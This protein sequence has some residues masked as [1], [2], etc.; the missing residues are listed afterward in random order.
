MS[1]NLE[2]QI[3]YPKIVVYN[4]VFEDCDKFLETAKNCEIWQDWYTFGTMMALQE[5][6]FKF[7]KFPTKEEYINAR[8]WE[9]NTDNNKKRAMLTKEIGEIFY[10]VT[11]HFLKLYPEEDLPN[12]VKN[13]A[14]VNKYIDNAGISQNYAMNYHTDFIHEE[15]DWASEKF[16]I[17]TTFYLNDNYENGE[18]CFKIGDHYISHKPKKGDV[19]VFPSKRP[20]LHAVRKATGADRYMIR[21]FWQYYYEGTLEWQDSIKK[22]GKEAWMEMEK[23]RIKQERDSLNYNIED[24]HQFFG[25][26]NGLY[27]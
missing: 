22:Y 3:I 23:D 16:G 4:N 17:T 13:P 9:Y 15:R 5:S 6:P 7:D 24:H 12:Y 1:D 25:K 20:Y 11:N 14:S 10:D 18:I 19:I 2:F 21:S 26:D 27:K 8:S